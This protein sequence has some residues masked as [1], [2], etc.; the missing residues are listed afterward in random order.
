MTLA[1][2]K[3][4]NHNLSSQG[5]VHQLPTIVAIPEERYLPFPLTDIQQGELG[6]SAGRR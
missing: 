6:R 2:A 1:P 5:F 3:L 4:E